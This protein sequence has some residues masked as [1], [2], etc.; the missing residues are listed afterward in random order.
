MKLP[1][2]ICC[3]IFG[4]NDRLHDGVLAVVCHYI[5]LKF[6]IESHDVIQIDVMAQQLIICLI[7]WQKVSQ[8]YENKLKHCSLFFS[9]GK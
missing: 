3:L 1:S 9:F 4:V 6:F 5:I 8:K 7:F 2:P